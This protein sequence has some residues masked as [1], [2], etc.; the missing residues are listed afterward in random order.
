MN[1]NKKAIENIKNAMESIKTLGL[2]Y[3]K[4]DPRVVA[5]RKA[6]VNLKLVGIE[7]E[8]LSKGESK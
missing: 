7:L 4:E 5:L 6:Y 3:D 1:L 2:A 8:N